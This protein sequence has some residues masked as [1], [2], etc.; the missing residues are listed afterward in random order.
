MMTLTIHIGNVGNAPCSLPKPESV[1]VVLGSTGSV[2]ATF[3]TA[4]LRSTAPAYV[5]LPPTVVPPTEPAR[6]E[7]MAFVWMIWDWRSGAEGP[8]RR[9]DHPNV[10]LVTQ[11]PSLTLRTPAEIELAPC[12]GR[13]GIVDFGTVPA[14]S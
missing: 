14:G 3:D 5:N 9:L 2:I 6:A 1:E 10:T 12:N 11:F 13:S 7:G 8:C 4:F